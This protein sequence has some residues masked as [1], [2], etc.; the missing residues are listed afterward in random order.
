MGIKILP[1]E[2]EMNSQSGPCY[3][4]NQNS[5]EVLHG[6]S[7]LVECQNCGIIYNPDLAIDSKEVS[8]KFYDDRN[9]RHRERIRSVLRIVAR[10]RWRWLQKRISLQVGRLLEIGCG[11][12]EFLVTARDAGWHV[13]GLELSEKFRHVAKIWYNL[14]LQGE[15][16]AKVDYQPQ[17]FDVVALLH[18]FEHV[19]N[20]LEVLDQIY[21]ILNP[22]GW[23]L[24]IVPNV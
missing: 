13:E 8:D 21:K 1:Q 17:S 3:L 19:P 24:I 22:S 15:E 2:L 20:P 16:L 12:G 10:S 23:L 6:F 18:V 11:T 14:E 7:W 9:A 5:L 4:C